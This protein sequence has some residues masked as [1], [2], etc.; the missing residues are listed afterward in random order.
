MKDGAPIV[1]FSNNAEFATGG[2]DWLTT[3]TTPIEVNIEPE[4]LSRNM[5][6]GKPA[7]TG[8]RYAGTILHWDL[9]AA[10][11]TDLLAADAGREKLWMKVVGLVSDQFRS[12]SGVRVNVEFVP[13]SDENNFDHYRISF[14]CYGSKEED[15]LTTQLF[16]PSP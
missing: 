12:F 1:Y 11:Y 2:D 5:A 8:I 16:D 9:T 10:L 14:S 13:N 4:P 3:L 6:D 7:S 15:I